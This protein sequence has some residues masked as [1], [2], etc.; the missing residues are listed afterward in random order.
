MHDGHFVGD[1]AMKFSRKNTIKPD[2]SS[3]AITLLIAFLVTSGC[4]SRPLAKRASVH[5]L[6]A[7]ALQTSNAD[8]AVDSANPLE[9]G[10]G[11]VVDDRIPSSF[12]LI[13]DDDSVSSPATEVNSLAPDVLINEEF[14]EQDIREVLSIIAEEAEIDLVLDPKVTGIVNSNLNDLPVG[15]AIEKVLMPLGFVFARHKNQ[16]VVCPADPASSLFSYVAVRRNYHPKHI[17]TKTLS[18]TLPKSL[19]EYT[20]V[21]EG[22][23]LIVIEA[24]DRIARDIE[25]RFQTIDQPIPQVVLEAIICVIEPDSAFQF[26]LDWGHAV[27]LDG[28]TV[29]NLGATGL[30][31]NGSFSRAGADALF[32]EFAKTSAFVKLL[33][34]HG[35]LT[36]RATPH[37]MARDGE[38][39]NISISRQTYFS[40][41]PS[42][43]SGAD[44][45]SFFFQQDVQEV[46][47]GIILDITPHVRGD[48]VTI[49]IEK[50]EVSE[51]VRN[52]NTELA[53]NPFPIISRRTVST[54][55]NVKDGRTI[56]IGG[57]VQRET[58]D[59]VNRIPGLS[60][61]PWMGYLFE[62]VQRQTREAEV[63]IFI[64][65]RI[66]K[67]PTV[68]ED[69]V[70]GITV[71][72]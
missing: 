71:L 10:M 5:E 27:E 35:Y 9:D 52:A 20:Q 40:V 48:T 17:D 26:G 60:R 32:S 24:P 63:V 62:T 61:L 53:L 14:V 42:N 4:V 38:Q 3:L 34:E 29:W 30:A 12:D 57:L 58:I 6:I 51:D 70:G 59:R 33:S 23:N 66:V 50:A 18:T 45:S 49:D 67:P 56:V 1:R 46:E 11:Y 8:M 68:T 15:A 22:S 54:L 28:E 47:S 21:I 16:V 39:A 65:P 13:I 69:C 44:N 36:I 7:Q 55:V 2:Q 31:M 43:S 37:V 72:P 64:S 19:V 25:D 41:Q